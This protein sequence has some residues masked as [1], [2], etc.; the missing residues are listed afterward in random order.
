MQGSKIKRNTWIFAGF[1]LLAGVFHLIEGGPK[2]YQRTVAFC[3]GFLIYTG[4]ILFWTFSVRERLLPSL[5]KT[6]LIA[7]AVLML[8]HLFA[9]TVKYRIAIY[10]FNLARLC[11]YLY[12]TPIVLTPTLFLTGS[13][14]F[15]AGSLRRRRYEWLLLIPAALI[16]LGV[17]TNDLHHLA[18]LPKQGVKQF[19]G[20][21]GTY[22]RGPLF[23][24]AYVWAGCMMAG[25]IV[26]LLLAT[27]KLKTWTR[28]VAPFLFLCLIPLL[29]AFKNRI[30]ERGLPVPYL[31]PEITI[32]CLIGLLESCI[33]SRLIPH[34]ENYAGFFS[35]LRM[36]AMITDQD[37]EPVLRS[38]VPVT[39]DAGQLRAALAGP[40]YP[41]PDTRLSGMALR[42]GY[43]FFTEDESRLNRVNEELR[44]AND[45]I[46]QENEI[47]RLE[48]D[49]AE[50]KAAVEER[51]RRYAKAAQET[52]P[53][54]KK[55]SQLLA[56]AEPD[57]P[58]FR[59]KIAKVLVLMAHVKRKTN[60]VLLEAERD[61]ITAGELA[62]AL[63]ESAHYLGSCGMNTSVSVTAVRDFPCREAIALYD[64]F[65]AAVEVLLGQTAELWVRLSD[66]ELLLMADGDKLPLLPEL[67]LPVKKACEDGQITVRIATGGERP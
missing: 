31:D 24:A 11:W 20:D 46:S 19:M 29:M 36:P 61:T 6:Y 35:K 3:A 2:G 18:F 52:Y 30:L 21:T 34:N 38:A 8:L 53:T 27:R 48:Q 14:H 23:Y 15:G 32:F 57:T 39:A 33:R 25:G 37:L 45:M 40:V 17:L 10:D 55:I 44:D 63:R 50:E 9:R 62:S 59:E 7:A 4:L 56:D 22:T 13:L 47:I 64:S 51:S 66:D 43:A 54:Q 67:P 16:A 28:A 58:A 65:E 26:R 49:L 60:F 42:A 12:Y 1:L 41:D 5:S